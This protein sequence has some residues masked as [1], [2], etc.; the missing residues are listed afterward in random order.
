MVGP[1]YRDW[2]REGK[3][4]K[5]RQP[6]IFTSIRGSSGEPCVLTLRV[7]AMQVSPDMKELHA[8]GKL[9]NDN[10]ADD[11]KVKNGAEN[12]E[13]GNDFPVWAPLPD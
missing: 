5:G 4:R 13:E 3:N 1:C 10:T 6:S 7:F 2:D 11:K 9:L 8:E 12:L